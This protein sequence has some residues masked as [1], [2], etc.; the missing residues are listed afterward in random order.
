MARVP[1]CGT[2]HVYLRQFVL[3]VLDL[4]DGRGSGFKTEEED[5]IVS[6]CETTYVYLKTIHIAGFGPE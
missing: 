5:A 3:R 1:K 2:T 6:K 4:K